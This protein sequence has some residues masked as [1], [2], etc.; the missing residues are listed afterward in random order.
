MRTKKKVL[1]SGKRREPSCGRREVIEVAEVVRRTGGCGWT[2]RVR[3]LL[4]I[5]HSKGK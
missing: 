5:E 2:F 1:K 4:I 3:A